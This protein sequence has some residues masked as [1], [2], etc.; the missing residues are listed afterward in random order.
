AS[1]PVPNASFPWSKRPSHR[2]LDLAKMAKSPVVRFRR[3]IGSSLPTA[4]VTRLP[5]RPGEF[6]PEPL[7][8]P[9]LTLSRHPARATARRLPP[10]IG[11]FSG[12]SASHAWDDLP[13]H[14][15]AFVADWVD[16]SLGTRMGVEIR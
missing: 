5:S 16:G 6:H 8:E 11:A 7:T 2:Q 15:D 13:V 10:S 4:K 1:W 9:D 12:A 3:K 14:V